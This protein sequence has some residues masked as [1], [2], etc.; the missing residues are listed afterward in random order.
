M[1]IYRGVRRGGS[2]KVTVSTKTGY[3]PLPPYR[4]LFNH[5][6]TGFNW[7]Y[8]GSGPAQLALALLADALR[9]QRRAVR[10]HQAFKRK[11]I[12]AL[13]VDE[14]TMTEYEILAT[15]T[16]IEAEQ[17]EALRA[18]YAGWGRS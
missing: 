2:A 13:K 16:Q 7:G 18:R 3:R 17:Q 8:E 15:V 4:K 11:K 14:W 12:G 5:S 10:L 1:R 6:P 9:D